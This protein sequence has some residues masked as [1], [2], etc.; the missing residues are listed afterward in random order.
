MLDVMVFDDI[1]IIRIL[2]SEIGIHRVSSICS[3]TR[4]ILHM[5]RKSFAKS[6]IS[7]QCLAGSPIGRLAASRMPV[8]EGHTYTYNCTFIYHTYSYS[9]TY[10]YTYN[11]TIPFL[12]FPFPARTGD[13]HLL[14]C[15]TGSQQRQLCLILS[16]E[17]KLQHD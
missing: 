4:M 6:V 12:H 1:N 17:Q 16:F 14:M 8:V 7:S 13:L 10:T 9:Y 15:Q 11:C 3:I 5:S 2:V